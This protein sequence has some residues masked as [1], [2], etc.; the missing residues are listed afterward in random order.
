MSSWQEARPGL[1]LPDFSSVTVVVLAFAALGIA[2]GYLIAQQSLVPILLLLGAVVGVALLNAL[3]L[4]I[5][6]VIAGVLVVSG[7]I[8]LFV[9]SLDRIGWAFSMLG[10]FL[11]MAALL[12]AAIGRT[13]FSTPAPGFVMLAAGF[14]IYG[15]L[16][17]LY[18]GG[19]LDEGVRAIKRYFQYYGVLF[20]LAVVPFAPKLV[21]R[22]W[23]VVILIGLLQLP[24][25]LYQ[26]V[27]LVPIREGMSGVVPLDIVAGT[28]EA[29]MTG[30]G[31]NGTLVFLLVVTIAFIVAALRDGL[32]SKPVFL[33]AFLAAA[34][35]IALGE[36]TFAIVL[37]PLALLGV[38]ADVIRRSPVRF[39]LALA[40][41]I[42]VLGLLAWVYVTS[43]SAS[44]QS[45]DQKLA[46][47]L[48][49]NF[50]SAGYFGTGLNRTTVYPYWWAQHGF[51]SD[52]V[53]TLFGHGLGSAFG[54]LGSLETGH[55][56]QEHR[57]MFIGLTAASAVLWDLG[58]LGLVLLLAIHAFAIARSFRLVRSAAP[59]FDRA[60]CRTL[61][62]AALLLP[63]M[64]AYSDAAIS[65]PSQ[66]VL[67]AILLGLIGWRARY[68][69]GVTHEASDP[70][71]GSRPRHPGR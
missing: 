69:A 51:G 50:G 12:Y 27:F 29:V 24:F 42:P 71:G 31:N 36:V 56:H 40:L 58:L 46:Q 19:P 34:T 9:P 23:R 10:F 60:L 1:R 70:F 13:R 11:A 38:N 55:M 26:R 53:T 17:L 59:G 61:F 30:G 49:Y 14:M 43:Y 2:A 5:W 41:M 48:E 44:G 8:M 20:I 62:A 39:S 35:P 54:A 63:L 21:E 68:R 37:L 18:S 22:W 4:V 3:S 64:L 15:V 6:I 32:I 57:G 7:P 33:A 47:I 28:M 67:A 45:F 16:S 66:E 65:T 25:A 52:P